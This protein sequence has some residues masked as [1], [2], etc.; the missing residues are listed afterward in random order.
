[1][2]RQPHSPERRE[3]EEGGGKKEGGGGGGKEGERK[4]ERG[5]EMEIAC[6]SPSVSNM[7]HHHCRYVSTSVHTNAHFLL[8]PLSPDYFLIRI[9]SLGSYLYCQFLLL[10]LRGHRPCF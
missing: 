3:R 4:G 9:L 6:H 5:R 1:M 2:A 8:C 7:P 10:S